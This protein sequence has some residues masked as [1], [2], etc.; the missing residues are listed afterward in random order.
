MLQSVGV[1]VFNL[2]FIVVVCL[3]TCI[4][5]YLYIYIAYD[6]YVYTHTLSFVGSCLFVYLNLQANLFLGIRDELATDPD[7]ALN[8]ILY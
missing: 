3:H 1:Y 2:A 5:M 8:G 6:E 4:C 7:D